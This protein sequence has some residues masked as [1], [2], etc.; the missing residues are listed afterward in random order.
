MTWEI[1]S[2]GYYEENSS[3]GKGACS[4]EYEKLF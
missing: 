4:P 1:G 2:I 3:Y